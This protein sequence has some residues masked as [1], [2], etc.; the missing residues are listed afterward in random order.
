MPDLA[1]THEAPRLD[2]V[3]H[4][5]SDERR[6]DM[7]AR[8]ADRPLTVSEL[9]EPAGLRLPA[10]M[11]HLAVLESGGLVESNKTGRTRTYRIRPDALDIIAG[12]VQQR[13]A[14]LNAAFDRLDEAI[15]DFPE[16][17]DT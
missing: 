11:K 16:G 13:R 4:A 7:V 15:A 6:R 14:S 2:T 10:A 1:P 12:W 17:R 9:A 5:L 3:F 8:L